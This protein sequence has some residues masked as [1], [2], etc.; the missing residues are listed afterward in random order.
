MPRLSHGSRHHAER[1][2]AGER[3][4][5]SESYRSDLSLYRSM[6]ETIEADESYTEVEKQEAIERIGILADASE[7]DYFDSLAEI[8]AAEGNMSQSESCSLDDGYS[9]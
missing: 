9:Y 4:A 8:N 1:D 2:F 6:A 7:R 3:D 5:L